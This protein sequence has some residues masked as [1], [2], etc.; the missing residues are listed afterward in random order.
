MFVILYLLFV[1][2]PKYIYIFVSGIMER[3]K[4]LSYT[5]LFRLEVNI[6]VTALSFFRTSA[7]H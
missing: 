7:R 5:F 2:Y 3:E 6:Y 1:L 4:D